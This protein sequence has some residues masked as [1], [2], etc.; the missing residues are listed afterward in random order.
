MF[1]WNIC[2]PVT[3]LPF[4]QSVLAATVLPKQCAH[5]LS[6]HMGAQIIGIRAVGHFFWSAHSSVLRVDRTPVS[7]PNRTS[8]W[9]PSQGLGCFQRAE[10]Q[11]PPRLSNEWNARLWSSTP[12][13]TSGS[14]TKITTW[15][16]D[17]S[18]CRDMIALQILKIWIFLTVRF[19]TPRRR[20]SQ[21]SAGKK[22]A[23][24]FQC[25]AWNIVEIS[26]C[27]LLTHFCL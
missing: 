4:L 10:E 15:R 19:F 22:L 24:I 25:T 11:R 5:A 7:P 2:P 9:D 20:A 14:Y 6:L 12:G 23:L 3:E 18:I 13:I 26:A 27:V 16:E 21:Q 17:V 8:K 1:D